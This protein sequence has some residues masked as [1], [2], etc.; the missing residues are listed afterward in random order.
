MFGLGAEYFALI[1]LLHLRANSKT[2]AAAA[3][4]KAEAVAKCQ[5]FK[6]LELDAKRGQDANV[7][8]IKTMETTKLHFM[9]VALIHFLKGIQ[10]LSQLECVFIYL[11]NVY[12]IY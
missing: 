4:S 3:A 11:L 10:G 1:E 12:L 9:L 8:Q 6:R 2:A 7:S 5:E